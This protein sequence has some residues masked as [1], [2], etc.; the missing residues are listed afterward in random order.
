MLNDVRVRLN[1]KKLL[2]KEYFHDKIM[3]MY[4]ASFNYKSNDELSF[5][6]LADLCKNYIELMLITNGNKNKC[7]FSFSENK[8]E[9]FVSEPIINIVLSLCRNFICFPAVETYYFVCIAKRGKIF[10]LLF[11]KS[12]NNNYY[13]DLLEVAIS[14]VKIKF[15]NMPSIKILSSKNEHS[16]SCLL[17]ASLDDNSIK[18]K[19]VIFPEGVSL[20]KCN[21][22]LFYF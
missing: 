9:E 17:N 13:D 7:K 20:K 21:L 14:K 3:K 15:K 10:Y 18:A 19:S 5:E 16:I 1:S 2:L 11:E 8:I 6:Q 22:P 12:L 4:F